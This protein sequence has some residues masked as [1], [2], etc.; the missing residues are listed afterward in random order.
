MYWCMQ[1]G[2]LVEREYPNLTYNS[3]EELRVFLNDDLGVDI[4]QGDSYLAVYRRIEAKLND[5]AFDRA[6]R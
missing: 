1:I 4:Q 2:A 5:R 3:Q 6:K